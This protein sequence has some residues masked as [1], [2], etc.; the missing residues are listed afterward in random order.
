GEDALQV[1]LVCDDDPRGHKL[2]AA[3]LGQRIEHVAGVPTRVAG[4]R[5]G[6]DRMRGLY[7]DPWVHIGLAGQRFRVSAPSFFQ[8]TL[9][10]AEPLVRLVAD[11]VRSGDRVLDLYSGVGTFALAVADRTSEVVGVEAHPIAAA[12]AQANAAEAGAEN[13]RFV[14][15]DVASST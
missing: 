4:M 12:D 5:A 3:E 8:I 10:V 13:V 1:A 7:E 11:E 15:A 6:S 14:L 2:Q 9:P